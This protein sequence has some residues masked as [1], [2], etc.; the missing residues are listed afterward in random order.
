VTPVA[1]DTTLNEVSWAQRDDGR[2]AGSFD[3]DVMA[4]ERLISCLDTERVRWF[5]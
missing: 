2:L 4:G 3:L 5:V 1:E